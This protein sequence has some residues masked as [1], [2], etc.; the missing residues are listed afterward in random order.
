MELIKYRDAGLPTYTYF[1]ISKD[2]RVLSPYFNSAEEAE[3]WLEL[4][5]KKLTAGQK[6]S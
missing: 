4:Q 2:N 1:W 6:D 3:K 5:H